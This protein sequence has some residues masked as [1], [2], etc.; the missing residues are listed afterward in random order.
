M[1]VIASQK[2]C[3]MARRPPA[4]QALCSPGNAPLK[5]GAKTQ[6][7]L[8]K[9]YLR[10]ALSVSFVPSLSVT[11]LSAPLVGIVKWTS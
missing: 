7:C 6:T 4:W 5:T 11:V 8:T 2:T 3:Q 9:R 10:L 1:A